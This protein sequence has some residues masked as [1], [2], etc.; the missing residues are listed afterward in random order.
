MVAN[1]TSNVEIESETSR[2]RA[3]LV[4]S[5]RYSF[6]EA[7]RT[8]A[9]SQLVISISDDVVDTVAGQA[10][11]LTAVATATRCFGTVQVCG[12]ME[13]PLM[14]PLHFALN[15]QNIGT[16]AVALGAKSDSEIREG[17]SV[18]VGAHAEASDTSVQ[19]FWNGWI[20]GTVPGR[21]ATSTGRSDCV[22]AG[23]AAGALA[24]GQSFLAEQGDL[25][26]SKTRG[27]NLAMDTVRRRERDSR[28]GAEGG[29]MCVGS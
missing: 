16:A 5:G 3:A 9:A 17:R 7:E 22:L 12:N 21:A 6:Q 25:R 1:M 19:A 4:N 2:I 26:A 27:E 29:A 13:H 23:V 8:L 28:S 15:S 18:L 14:L 20:V 10:A 24:V 11:F